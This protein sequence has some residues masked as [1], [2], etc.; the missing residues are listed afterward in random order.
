[1]SESASAI[2]RR[3]SYQAY[4]DLPDELRAEYVNGVVIVNPPPSFVHQRIC[5]RL[6]DALVT[7]LPSA[8]VAVAVGWKLSPDRQD[9]RIPDVAVLDAEPAEDLVAVPPL[10]V[11]EVL[12][13]NRSD[14]LVR[15]STEYLDAGAGQYWIMDP[16]DRV[17]D[18]YLSTPA[19]WEVLAHLTDEHP[20]GVVRVAELGDVRLDLAALLG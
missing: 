20:T 13:T 17:L 8:V 14:D 7:A 5:L 9:I 19:G 1:M 11:V 10:L 3:V 12:S 4:L 2:G 18:A 15:K 16:R 6:R